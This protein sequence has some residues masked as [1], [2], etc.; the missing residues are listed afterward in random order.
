MS[1]WYVLRVRMGSE[2]IIEKRLN[3]RIAE[4]LPIK[5]VVCPVELEYYMVKGKKHVR[6]RVIYGG[7]LYVESENQIG[8]E[9]VGEIKTELDVKGFLGTADKPQRLP[10]S[11]VQRIIKDEVLE[12]RIADKQRTITVESN[13]KIIDGPFN[14]FTGVVN[15]ISPEKNRVQVVVQIF[16]RSQYVDLALNQIEKHDL[17]S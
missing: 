6:D 14:D 1:N 3:Q 16:G 17:T 7:Y 2:R 8:K 4:G 12:K 5:R 13:V 9:V 15:E 11:D 10:Q